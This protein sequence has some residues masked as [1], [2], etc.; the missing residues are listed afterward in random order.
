M[1]IDCRKCKRAEMLYIPSRQEGG[2]QAY[3]PSGLVRCDRRGRRYVSKDKKSA[4]PWF[5]AKRSDAKVTEPEP[6]VSAS[7]EVRVLPTGKTVHLP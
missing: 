6:V 5:E 7:N 2:G 4:C 1:T 3:T